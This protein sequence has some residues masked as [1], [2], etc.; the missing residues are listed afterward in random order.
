MARPLA[1]NGKPSPS[2]TG[3][4]PPPTSLEPPPAP[5]PVDP[6]DGSL[7][8]KRFALAE[9]KVASPRAGE[10]NAGGPA[11]DQSQ[12][13]AVVRRKENQDAVKVCYDRALK[14]DSRLSGGRVNVTVTV[15]GSGIVKQVQV[16]AAA[17][18]DA[19]SGCI[20]DTVKRWRFPGGGEEYDFQF[21]F[22]FQRDNSG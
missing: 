20:R 11:F 13:S 3:V 5:P 10:G 15:G 9:R 6:G 22:V 4:S 1:A 14:R 8:T 2:H 18:M 19:V 12:V 21:P 17:D 7:A 16:D